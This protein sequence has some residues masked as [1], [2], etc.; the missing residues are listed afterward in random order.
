[1]AGASGRG[2][3]ETLYMVN[4]RVGGQPPRS[5][6]APH[7]GK[8]WSEVCQW[9]QQPDG[10]VRT[11]GGSAAAPFPARS[12][13]GSGLPVSPQPQRA[14]RPQR[15]PHGADGGGGGGARALAGRRASSKGGACTGDLLSPQGLYRDRGIKSG[16]GSSRGC[17]TG[18]SRSATSRSSSRDAL[19]RDGDVSSRGSSGWETCTN[20]SEHSRPNTPP[21]NAL[22]ATAAA[23]DLFMPE[24]VR[25]SHPGI[26]E[27]HVQTPPAPEPA[28]GTEGTSFVAAVES[29]AVSVPLTPGMSLGRDPCGRDRDKHAERGVWS[30]APLANYLKVVAVQID[31][32]MTDRRTPSAE[33]LD[34]FISRLVANT[35]RQLKHAPKRERKSLQDLFSK[36]F[37]GFW[38][39]TLNEKVTATTPE[40]LKW[41]LISLIEN[42]VGDFNLS[43]SIL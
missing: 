7:G 8:N 2:A 32:N 30:V 18:T 16:S 15:G 35:K 20:S 24:P 27:E 43:P 11:S 23:K 14:F 22:V 31:K 3:V 25:T 41:V 9:V 19:A 1:M 21:A 4:T 17:S 33:R 42:L 28:A 6:T 36:G 10:S 38:N 37:Q 13:G 34:A 12:G 39:F 5:G 26:L 29:L 40:D